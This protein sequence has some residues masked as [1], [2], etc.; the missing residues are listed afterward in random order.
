[1]HWS[2]SVTIFSTM[3]ALLIVIP[4]PLVEIPLK[5]FNGVIDF[6]A[7]CNLIKLIENDF[8]ESF[9]NAI[10]LWRFCLD[11]GVVNIR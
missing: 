1:M 2:F 10:G 5:H 4:H 6:F 3:R 8:M 11:F 7:E 9:A